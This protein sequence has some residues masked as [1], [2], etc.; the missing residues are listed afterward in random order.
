L[1]TS[2]TSPSATPA[3]VLDTKYAR[4]EARNAYGGLSFS[5][6]HAYQIA[7]YARALDCPGALVYPRFDR[8]VATDFVVR[9]TPI[10]FLT[11][12]LAAPGLSGLDALACEL[13]QRLS[14]VH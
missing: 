6:P 9:G 13:D 12:D 5:N 11:V 3:L 10:T 4:P 7:F 1:S 2:P 8:D 14:I